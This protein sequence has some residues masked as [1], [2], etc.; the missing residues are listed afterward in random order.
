MTTSD[1]GAVDRNRVSNPTTLCELSHLY[2]KNSLYVE[3]ILTGSGTSTYVSSSY[4]QMAVSASGDRVVRQSKEYIPYQLGKS[5]LS[6]FTGVLIYPAVDSNVRSRIGLFDDSSDK[7]VDTGSNNSNGHFFQLVG[8]TLSVVE[9]SY[10]TDTVINQS[11]WNIDKFDSTGPSGLILGSTNFAN[12]LL[13]V[14]DMIWLGVG[15]V[16][17]GFMIGNKVWYCHR[18]T[19]TTVIDG[20]TN[21]QIPY[22][23]MGKMPIRYEI[24]ATGTPITGTEMRMICATAISE[25]GFIPIGRRF[26]YSRSGTLTVNTTEL[27][28]LSIRVKSTYNRMTLKPISI[29]VINTATGYATYYIKLNPTLTGASFRYWWSFRCSI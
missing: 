2:D 20:G 6:Y 21:F 22:T 13:F 9:R 18:I 11:S 17:F 29:N 24:T 28:V 23:K 16:R 4:I 15:T 3:E 8:S 10:G 14:I 7:S 12:N 25:G 19:H 27:P 1:R 26:S 5:R